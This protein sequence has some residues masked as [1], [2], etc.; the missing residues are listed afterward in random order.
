MVT[1]RLTNV[2]QPT[3]LVHGMNAQKWALSL[4]RKISTSRNW[5]FTHTHSLTANDKAAAS[6]CHGCQVQIIRCQSAK[7]EFIR[8]YTYG[9]NRTNMHTREKAG[10]RITANDPSIFTRT[11]DENHLTVMTPLQIDGSILEGTHQREQQTEHCHSY[12]RQ[13]FHTQKH[14]HV[15]NDCWKIHRNIHI[16]VTKSADSERTVIPQGSCKCKKSQFQSSVVTDGKKTRG[17]IN[18]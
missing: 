10:V 1:H 4:G 16:T 6:T 17:M 2:V 15:T 9:N 11:V 5:H 3:S 12:H 13:Q 14:R 18:L 7:H 8:V